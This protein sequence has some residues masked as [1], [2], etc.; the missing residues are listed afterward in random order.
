LAK[1]T[2]D[3]AGIPG[4][5]SNSPLSAPLSGDF[6]YPSEQRAFNALPE[7]QQRVWDAIL[8]FP[9]LPVKL[10]ADFALESYKYQRNQRTKPSGCIERDRL[11]TGSEYANIKECY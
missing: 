4:T 8:R 9:W 5:S 7:E 11:P 10:R 6:L 1:R 2:A 3:V